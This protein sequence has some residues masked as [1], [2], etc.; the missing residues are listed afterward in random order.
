MI[1]PGSLANSVRRELPR[2]LVDAVQQLTCLEDPMTFR[3][4]VNRFNPEPAALGG[5]QRAQLVRLME[6]VSRTPGG[7]T[8]MVQT[9]E[10][11]EGSTVAVLNLKI[12]LAAWE[13]D[14]FAV[15][16]WEE[17]FRLLDGLRVPDLG[18]RYADFLREQGRFS[19]PVHCT[20]P[21]AVFLHASTLNARNG[22]PLPC[23]Q[24]LRR[25]AFAAE[26]ERQLALMEW[27][28]AHDPHPT[29]PD[30]AGPAEPA[31]R[32]SQTETGVWRPSDYLI[33][34]LRPLLDGETEGMTILSY[35]RRV[36]PGGQVRGED[37][38]I[39]LQDL[40]R[41]VRT[42]IHQA[43]SDWAY[44]LKGELAIEFVLPWDLLHLPV[45]RW[46]KSSFRGIGAVLGEDHPVVIRSLERLD[47]RDL[48]GRWGRRWD[49]FAEGRAGRAHWFADDGLP[50][51][52]SDPPPAVAVLSSAPGSGSTAGEESRH[53]PDELGEALRAG[54]PVVLWDRRGR[55]GPE[56]RA[57]IR[58]VLDDGDPRRLPAL[59]K[60]LR[61]TSRDGDSEG[62]P[63]VGRHVA[64]LW[65]DP[66]RLPVAATDS[67][68]SVRDGWEEKQTHDTV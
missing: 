26:G 66:Y 3:R 28:D 11:W 68:P 35:W 54:I 20:E 36:H 6:G 58:A 29:V 32:S 46:E 60:S 61:I 1:D 40:E 56:F 65:D 7:L 21:W 9:L 37:R 10:V 30:D 14:L 12:A 34:R 19:A 18:R 63:V 59:V 2:Y 5:G 22:Q 67:S 48:H 55:T 52:L 53:T 51:L 42:L 15:E 49:A 45:E 39:A 25:L 41:E 23:L 27:A 47:R 50:H 16:E 64:L 24:L 62:A 38:R 57:A 44:F 13:V 33:I 4:L 31:Y 43:E 8:S 17:L